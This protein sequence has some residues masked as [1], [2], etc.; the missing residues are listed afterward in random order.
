MFV[1]DINEEFYNLIHG[2][3]ILLLVNNDIDAICASKIF[4]NLFKCISTLYTLVTVEG[5]QELQEIYANYS[6]QSKFILLINCGGTVDIVETLQPDEDVIVF[7]VD[8]HKPTDVCNVYSRSQVRIIG[9]AEENEHIPDFED[10]FLDSDAE[11]EGSEDELGEEEIKKRREKKEWV[12]KRNRIMF[13]YTQFSF[14]GRASSLIVYELLWRLGKENIDCLWW[15]IIGLTFQL[16]FGL[17]EESKYAS[18]LP[19]LQLH[20]A[21]LA[22]A[23]VDRQKSDMF[24]I[25]T[26]KDLKLLLY[27][28]WTVQASIRYSMI[29]AIKLRLWTAQG[30]KRL[31]QLLAEVGL[32]LNES[33]QNYTSMD[34]NLRNEFYSM[35]EGVTSKYGLENLIYT[36]FV[37]SHGFRNCYQSADYVYG[38]LAILDNCELNDS[39]AGDRFLHA[40]DSLSRNKY[41]N[42]NNGIEKAKKLLASIYKE[43]QTILDLNQVI[44]AGPF[45]YF[46]LNEN[47]AEGKMFSTPITL[48]TLARYVLNFYASVS[49]SKKT[50]LLPLIASASC[51]DDKCIVLGIPPA[52]ELFPRNFFGKA[53][54]RASEIV[55]IEPLL[56][57]FDTSVI[58]IKQSDRPKFFDA[59]VTIL[60]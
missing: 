45:L 5:L 38:L 10:I 30:E 15:A 42:L 51:T 13:E 20:L 54:E 7:I 26:Q 32:P 41:Q 59:L 34:F 27:R 49:R 3:H 36:C 52:S 47:G 19:V 35:V 40:M 16:H 31:H 48:L 11:S 50:G 8:S 56:N 24:K 28:H 39:S 44:S 37:L 29:T 18:E 60:S 12:D 21:R 1:E 23:M 4:Q 58:K 9:K 33:L 17:I 25:T 46:V 57:Y 22:P 6:E 55:G 53:F 2:K 14:Y 43:V